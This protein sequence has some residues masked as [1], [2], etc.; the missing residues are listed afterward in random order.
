[1]DTAVR[2]LNKWLLLQCQDIDEY[3]D[4]ESYVANNGTGARLRRALDI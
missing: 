3:L 1:M 2:R 4:I